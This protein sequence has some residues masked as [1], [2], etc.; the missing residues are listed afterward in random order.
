MGTHVSVFLKYHR[1]IWVIQMNGGTVPGQ[2][3]RVWEENSLPIAAKRWKHLGTPFALGFRQQLFYLH[4]VDEEMQRKL[5]QSGTKPSVC[6]SVCISILLREPTEAVAYAAPVKGL[7][8]KG[9]RGIGST[10]DHTYYCP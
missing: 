10:W 9:G 7:A 2:D 3:A 4:Y 8:Q 5:R 6:V 1:I